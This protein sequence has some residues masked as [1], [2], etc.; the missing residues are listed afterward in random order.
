MAST[1]PWIYCRETPEWLLEAV[2]GLRSWETD[3]G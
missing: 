3:E 1:E 2:W